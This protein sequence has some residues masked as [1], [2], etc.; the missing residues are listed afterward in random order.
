MRLIHTADWHLGRKL[1]GQERTSEIELALKQILRQAQE[2]E[3]DA[4]LVAGDIFD[5]YNPSAEAHRVAYDFFTGLSKA[6]IPAI[7]I[8][9]NHDN[10]DWFE[11]ISSLFSM[12]GVRALGR[13][14]YAEDGGLLEV[15]TR[16]GLLRIGALPFASQRRM[17]QVHELWTQ[18]PLQRY[19]GYQAL[20]EEIT[21]DLA[22][23]FRVDGV[24]VLMSHLSL[25]AA[26]LSN[27][28][29]PYYSREDYA[30]SEQFLPSKAQ[31][32]ALGHVHKPQQIP[33]KPNAWYSGSLIQVDF[34]EAGEDKFFN[35]IE[36]EPGYPAKV[37][38]EPLKIHKPLKVL[39]CDE[40]GLDDVI[41]A[42]RDHDGWLKLQVELSAPKPALKEYIQ[43]TLPQ[44]LIVEGLFQRC[45]TSKV[46]TPLEPNAD[47]VGAFS[48]YLRENQQTEPSDHLLETFRKLYEATR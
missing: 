11:S 20:L 5:H 4:V 22:M 15:P 32:I 35:L 1:A 9:G 18:D 30:I 46:T 47:P 33:S 38:Q 26:T 23:H 8:A 48:R 10:G 7:A 39:R 41:E 42:H 27:S 2:L 24:N 34:G 28:E 12:V 6:G 36:V 16:S 40:K 45:E 3:T 44:T 43:K 37:Y 31:Y 19:Q 17:V 25:G 29:D 21:G 14:R 13:P